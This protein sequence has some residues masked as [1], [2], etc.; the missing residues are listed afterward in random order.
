MTKVLNVI[1][2]DKPLKI[3]DIEI[4][5]YVLEG[6]IR[7]L[8]R[9]GM[10]KALGIL[11][12]PSS[13]DSK[14]P[15]FFASKRIN[16]FISNKLAVTL[17][18]PFFFTPP[19]GGKPIYGYHARLIP[20][21]CNVIVDANNAGVLSERE[22]HIVKQVNKLV[23]GLMG[24]AIISLVDNATGYERQRRREA[25]QEILNEYLLEESRPWVKTFPIEFYKEL[26]RLKKWAWESLP[27]E[28]KPSTPSVV[29]KYTNELV[30]KRLFPGFPKELINELNKLNPKNKEGN[31]LLRHHQWFEDYKGLPLLKQH[32]Y[33][34]VTLMRSSASWTQF[35]RAVKRAFPTE[36]DQNEMDLD[37]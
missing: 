25:L 23:R 31:R 26:F 8:S 15:R 3:G 1:A 21:L 30:Y 5:C 10:V 2:H 12:N 11:A 6:E 37:D 28:K 19:H 34:I 35:E 33:A 27:D 13:G 14:T 18:N 9:R 24:V 7:V 36:G 29:G 16:P 22:A 17:S 4:D 20:D 32:I